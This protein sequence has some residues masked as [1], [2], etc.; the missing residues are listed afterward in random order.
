[1]SVCFI[2]FLKQN[3]CVMCTSYTHQYHKNIMK[4]EGHVNGSQRSQPVVKCNDELFRMA[5]ESSD[6]T[7]S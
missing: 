7:Q 2:D 4:A 6:E 1:M 3:T 5:E